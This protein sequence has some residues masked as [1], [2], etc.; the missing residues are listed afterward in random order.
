M[1]KEDQLEQLKQDKEFLKLE[2]E[3]AITTEYE[4]VAANLDKIKVDLIIL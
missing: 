3:T 1:F 2:L 4:K